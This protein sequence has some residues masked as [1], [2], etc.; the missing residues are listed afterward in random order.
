MQ[1]IQT[2]TL[3]GQKNNEDA[4][5]SEESVDVDKL[6]IPVVRSNKAGILRSFNKLAKELYFLLSTMFTNT[7]IFS[8]FIQLLYNACLTKE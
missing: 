5:E 1:K 8:K 6:E 7:R 3:L 4:E 2:G